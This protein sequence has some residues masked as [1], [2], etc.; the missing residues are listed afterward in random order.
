MSDEKF[1]DA[2]A[3]EAWLIGKDVDPEKA[4]AVFQA[5]FDK[6]YDFPSTLIGISFEALTRAGISDP[7]AQMLSNKLKERQ[8]HN[9][10]LRCCS[11]I[12]LYSICLEFSCIVGLTC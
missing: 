12:F 5:L 7:V 1:Q 9:C 4:A 11:R 3:L 10:E 8:Q 6:G 2:A